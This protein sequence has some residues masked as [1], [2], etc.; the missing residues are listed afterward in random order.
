[1]PNAAV[2]SIKCPGVVLIAALFSEVVYAR[3]PMTPPG[4]A[5]F[6]SQA[7][8]GDDLKQMLQSFFGPDHRRQVGD[9]YR[10]MIA[11]GRCPPGLYRK[12]QCVLPDREPDWRLGHPLPRQVA[13]F[14]LPPALVV[15][16]GQPPPGYG[17]VRV[18]ADVL[19]IALATGVVID[20]IT[21]LGQ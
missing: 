7:A 14:A 19:L 4:Q 12:R 20:A 5:K 13:R 16:L 10:D 17:Y 11:A 2:L 18:D 3:P 9:Y 6:Y 21:H 1:M 8:T 15:K